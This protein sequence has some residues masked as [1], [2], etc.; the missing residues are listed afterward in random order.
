VIKDGQ[1]EWARAYGVTRIGGSPATPDTL[2]QAASISKPVSALAVMQLVQ[3][4]K[5][6]LDADVNEY[7]RSWRLPASD[8]AKTQKVTLRRLLSHSAGM[9]VHGFAGY[10]AGEKVPTLVEV[11]NGAA[12]ANSAPIR[13]DIERDRSFATPA[14]DTK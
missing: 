10:A 8:L 7:L 3:E 4:G 12:P 13:V 6:N 1:I 14:A 5:L 11:L 2:F 9:T